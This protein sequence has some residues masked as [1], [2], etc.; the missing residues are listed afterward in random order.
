MNNIIPLEKYGYSIPLNGKMAKKIGYTETLVL[1]Q[2]GY[3]INYHKEMEENS[4][5]KKHFING[6]W[7]TYITIQELKQQ[8]YFLSEKS[9]R[10]AV[11]NLSELG[12]LVISHHSGGS[13]GRTNWYSIDCDL[14]D[15]MMISP[16]EKIESD[17]LKN[18]REKQIDRNKQVNF[19]SREDGKEVNF[20]TSKSVNFTESEVVNFTATI[21][22]TTTNNKTYTAINSCSLEKQEHGNSPQAVFDFMRYKLN[23]GVEICNN[24]KYFLEKYEA[25]CHQEHPYIS[26]ENLLKIYDQYYNYWSSDNIEYED[27]KYIIDDYFNQTFKEDCDYRI[28]HFFSGDIIKNLYYHV[29]ESI[30]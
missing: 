27:W 25:F 30:C 15:R 28:F 13:Y 20:T 11:R 12:L 16:E 4:Q 6:T 23:S 3:W 22:D 24:I 7:T 14:L 8:I 5:Q 17:W 26:R 9:I 18:E 10:T 19:T 2:I 1:T 21:T 29:R